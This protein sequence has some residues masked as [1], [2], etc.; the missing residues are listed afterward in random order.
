[1]PQL[2]SYLAER[3]FIPL[4]PFVVFGPSVEYLGVTHTGEGHLHH[5]PSIQI[6]APLRDALT[7]TP[8]SNV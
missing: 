2:K 7:G 1:M 5:C 3:E 4:P 8:R 6:L